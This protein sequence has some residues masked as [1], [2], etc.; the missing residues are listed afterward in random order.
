VKLL[1]TCLVVFVTLNAHANERG[2]GMDCDY[3]ANILQQNLPNI[4]NQNVTKVGVISSPFLSDQVAVFRV[5]KEDAYFKEL[6]P[7]DYRSENILELVR[8]APNVDV[9][10][11]QSQYRYREIYIKMDNNSIFLF[12]F[13]NNQKFIIIVDD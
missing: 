1:L 3:F 2:K 7:S 10:I 9:S 4:D 5:E 6:E 12:S 11:P 8:S 13:D